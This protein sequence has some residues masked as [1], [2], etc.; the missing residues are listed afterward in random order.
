MSSS[1]L[2]GSAREQ[3]LGVARESIAS[4]LWRGERLTVHPEDFDPELRVPR[5]SF[6]TLHRRGDLRGCIGSLEATRPLVTD[7]CENARA[8]AFSDPRFPQLAAGEFDQLSI[9][10]SVLSPPVDIDFQDEADLI[11]QLRPAIDGVVLRDGALRGTFLPS[12]W[13]S[14]PDPASFLSHLKQKAG[15]PADHW[16]DTLKAY[17]YTTESFG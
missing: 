8:A 17:R 7:V 15:L 14:L 6:V 16:S 2:P 3:L 12:V 9:S 1:E 13:E 11:S 4:K 5:A 10:I